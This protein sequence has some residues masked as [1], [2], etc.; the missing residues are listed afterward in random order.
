MLHSVK[1]KRIL[2]FPTAAPASLLPRPS[3]GS[4]R[5]PR[6]R[7]HPADRIA[8][9]AEEVLKTLAKAALGVGAVIGAGVIAYPFAFR[10]ACSAAFSRVDHDKNGELDVSEVKAAIYELY[11]ALNK[12]LPGWEDPPSTEDIKKA[13]A[14]VD[15]DNNGKLNKEEWM[16]FCDEF[17]KDGP[18]F[19][20]R[21]TGG[22]SRN[23]GVLPAA[24]KAS[25]QA[26]GTVGS[27]IPE[28]CVAG[29]MSTATKLVAGI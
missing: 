29:V 11:N 10:A 18:K 12:R 14:T 17:F 27:A 22:V 15:A 25:K 2:P 21:M 20:K 6:R 9:K 5:T 7:S 1:N 3:P 8:M 24:A 28:S 23:V 19:F 13:M 4:P 16:K 26:L